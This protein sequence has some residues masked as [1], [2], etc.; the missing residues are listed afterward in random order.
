MAND[1]A[2]RFREQAEE[3]RQ[4]AEKATSPLGKE[5]WLRVA[6]EWIKLGQAAA[7]WRKLPTANEG[8]PLLAT[9]FIDRRALAANA[10]RDLS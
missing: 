10:L 6:D 2:N 3:C 4:Q 8:P 5:A 1:D 9:S 7:S